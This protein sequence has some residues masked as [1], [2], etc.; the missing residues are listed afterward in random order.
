MITMQ[1]HNGIHEDINNARRCFV[2]ATHRDQPAGGRPRRCSTTGAGRPTTSNAY[3]FETDE[4][5][6]DAFVVAGA[7][8]TQECAR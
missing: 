2:E 6:D 3:P 5:P 8:L 1:L 7:R 4:V